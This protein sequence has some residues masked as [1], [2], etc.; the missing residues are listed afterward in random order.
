MKRWNLGSDLKRPRSALFALLAL[1]L[2]ASV[3]SAQAT[4]ST[5]ESQTAS[6]AAAAAPAKECPGGTP[7]SQ[8]SA[9]RPANVRTADSEEPGSELVG[10]VRNEATSSFAEAF[11]YGIEGFSQ[12]DKA[13]VE[14]TLELIDE[15]Y[16][17]TPIIDEARV[18]VSF[19]R[20]MFGGGVEL[21]MAVWRDLTIDARSRVVGPEFAMLGP[22]GLELTAGAYIGNIN[23]EE[24]WGR[25][26]MARAQVERAFGGLELLG[27]FERGR[28][29]SDGDIRSLGDGVYKKYE[30]QVVFPLAMI[31]GLHRLAGSI[32]LSVEDKQTTFGGHGPDD[33]EISK[34]LGY[35]FPLNAVATGIANAV[36]RSKEEPSATRTNAV[37]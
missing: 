3:V 11:R 18:A 37:P 5:P 4:S 13:K 7:C 23:I 2:S 36:H 24:S 31:P 26:A 19:S 35:E 20:T 25:F 6:A 21:G 33:H 29:H 16:V 28:I 1:T 34:I 12:G 14:A 17:R 22:K 9:E 32:A 30:A 8:T 27:N 10:A 15:A